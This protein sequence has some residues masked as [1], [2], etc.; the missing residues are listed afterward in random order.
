MLRDANYNAKSGA[1]R[2]VSEKM[3]TGRQPLTDF[4]RNLC[5]IFVRFFKNRAS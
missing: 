2:R 3:E 1:V 4:M 5:R